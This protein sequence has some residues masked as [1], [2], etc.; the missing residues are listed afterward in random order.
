MKSLKGFTAVILDRRAYKKLKG[1]T[2]G[3]LDHNGK[4][5]SQLE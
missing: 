1:F 2:T 4:A 5:D 3:I